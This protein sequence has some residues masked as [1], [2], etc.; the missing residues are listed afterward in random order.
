MPIL[1]GSR[2]LV[3]TTEWRVKKVPD[4][5]AQVA[6]LSGGDI[7]KER[8]Q[9]EDGV[10]AVLED[11]DFDFKYKVQQFTVET[12]G[13]GGYVNRF[14]TNGNRFTTEQKNAFRGVNRE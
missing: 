14:P 10:M 6:G 9:I 11:F 12:T 5:V 7:R 2:K 1:D 4:P 8:L 13:Q 3:G